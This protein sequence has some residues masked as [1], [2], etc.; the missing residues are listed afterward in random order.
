MVKIEN[1]L[2][3]SAVIWVVYYRI[4]S[5][6]ACTA[7]LSS[8]KLGWICLLPLCSFHNT[9][10]LVKKK[11][12]WMES[13]IDGCSLALEHYPIFPSRAERRFMRLKIFSALYQGEG[14]EP[15]FQWP[16]AEVNTTSLIRQGKTNH[17]NTY[18][19]SCFLWD[20]L[21]WHCCWICFFF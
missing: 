5:Y 1:R 12:K 19:R 21:F 18:V 8:E 9:T 16:V 15:S 3:F 10:F 4:Q 11:K 14:S 6:R 7:C 2:S 17:R 13:K 20:D